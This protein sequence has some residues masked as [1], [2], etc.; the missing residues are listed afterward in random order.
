MAK[1]IEEKFRRAY[2]YGS[3]IGSESQT[4]RV[5]KQ[6]YER[7]LNAGIWICIQHLVH[8]HDQ[9]SMASEI[10]D[11]AGFSEKEALECQNIS[12]TFNEEMLKFIKLNYEES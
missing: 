8:Y 10:L 2:N 6:H 9:P 1:K 4:K 12:G 7:G 3:D 5:E 11:A